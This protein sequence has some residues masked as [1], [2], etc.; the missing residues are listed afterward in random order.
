MSGVD[1]DDD[2]F[3][4]FDGS[5][6][7][8]NDPEEAAANPGL[9]G[10]FRAKADTPFETNGIIIGPDTIGNSVL[11][12]DSLGGGAG[13]LADGHTVAPE[14]KENAARN[15]MAR[16][17]AN[18]DDSEKDDS[19]DDG[20]EAEDSQDGDED[21][22]EEDDDDDDDENDSDEEE[23]KVD[24]S[25]EARLVPP[26]PI[27]QAPG[28]DNG[29]DKDDESFQNSQSSRADEEIGSEFGSGIG[30]SRDIPTATVEQ[31]DESTSRAADED[32]DD[33]PP[34]VVSDSIPFRVVSDVAEDVEVDFLDKG[35]E[36]EK[37]H[38]RTK[39]GRHELVGE[40]Y[41]EDEV[42][43]DVRMAEADDGPIDADLVMPGDGSRVE[44]IIQP[45]PVDRH[46]EYEICAP[47][48]YVYRV[49]SRT[50]GRS[51]YEIEYDDGARF[52]IYEKDL[53]DLPNG[54]KALHKFKRRELEE[55]D[56]LSSAEGGLKRRRMRLTGENMSSFNDMSLDENRSFNPSSAR[57]F[58]LEDEDLMDLDLKAQRRRLRT[59]AETGRSGIRYS[60][61]LAPTN[62]N[63]DGDEARDGRRLRARP[64]TEQSRDVLS[65]RSTRDDDVDELGGEDDA[66]FIPSI[67]SDILPQKL[68]RGNWKRR[69]K[70]ST[71]TAKRC[72][73]RD[74]SIEFETARRSSRANKNTRSMVEPTNYN[75]E[76]FYIEDDQPTQPRIINVK[77]VFQ[78]LEGPSPFR[79]A[80]MQIC[81]SCSGPAR[82]P[83]KG[84]MI[85][86]Q[87]C[88]L[89]FHK[90]CIGLRKTREH[91]VTKVADD[92]FVLQCR[93]CVNHAKI[94]DPS[95]P[96]L[97]KCSVCSKVGLSCAPFSEKKPAK[98]EERLRE[99]N[100]G[101]DP[102]TPV[103]PNLVDNAD[104]VLFR[105]T[106]CHRGFHYQHLPPP[107][108]DWIDEA[109][110]NIRKERLAEYSIDGKC[111]DC[112]DMTAK[113]EALIAWR[114]VGKNDAII[115][116][117]DVVEDDKEYLIKWEDKSY[118][119]CEWRPGSWV[120]GA[121]NTRIRQTLIK[122][123]GPAGVPPVFEAKDAFPEEYLYADIIFMVRY[124]RNVK[125]RSKKEGLACIGDI[126]QIM[127]KFQGLGY[128][129]VV[130]DEPPQPDSGKRWTTFVSA[131]DEYLNGKHFKSDSL[132]AMR[133]RVK[134]FQA[135]KKFEVISK[136]P[137]VLRRGKL[138]P[139]QM[140]GLNWLLLNY[141]KG[142]S[143]VLA[144]EM[145]LGKTVQVIA[146][147]STLVLET[148]RTW[149][150]LVVVPNS[151]CANWRREIKNWAPDLRVVSYHGGRVPQSMA[152][153]YELFP[154]GTQTMHAHVVIMSY[155]SAQDDNTRR[156]F[157]NVR[158]SGLVVD[159]GQRLKNDQNLL[160]LAL[161]AMR[162]SFRL[163]LTGTPL[164][165]NKRELF[166]LLQFIDS[167]NNA[168]ELDKTYSTITAENLPEL[169]KLIRP[170]FLRRTKAEVLKFLPPM[171]QIIVPVSMTVVQEKLC[172][173][174][175]AKNP[176][177]IRSIFSKDQVKGA[178]RGS[179]N[180][181]LMQLRKCLCHPFVYSE[182][183]EDKSVEVEQMHRNLIEASAKLLLLKLMLP[184]LKERGHRVLIFSQFLNQLDII[185]DFLHIM[186]M[187][188]QR[189]DGSLSS[190]EKQKRIDAYNTP[191]SDLFAFLLSTRAGGVGINLA[192]AD[193]V[194]VLDPDFNP[195]QDIQAFSRAHRIGQKKKV[196]CFQFMTK[197]SVE[198][199]I[200]QIGRSKMA[201]DHALI[202]TMD[203]EDD[204]GNDLESILRHGAQA[205][206]SE[207]AAQNRIV[208]DDASVDKLLDRSQV[209]NTRTDDERTAES[210]FSFARVWANETGTLA[211][212]IELTTSASVG[213]GGAAV[214]ND[215]ALS[216][217][218]NII[219][220]REAEAARLAEAQREV[221]GRGGRRRNKVEYKQPRYNDNDGDGFDGDGSDGVDGPPEKKSRK[222]K[223]Q[224]VDEDGEFSANDGSSTDDDDDDS[225]SHRRSRD[226]PA[227][228]L[229]AE[230]D[231]VLITGTPKKNAKSAK[232]ATTKRRAMPSIPKKTP[233]VASP[234]KAT[235]SK[236]I[237]M[238][239]VAK[240]ASAP[241]VSPQKQK[242]AVA[243]K[244]LAKSKKRQ[245]DTGLKEIGT[246]ASAM[247]S[248]ARKSKTAQAQL[249]AAT[250][251]GPKLDPKD[252]QT[253]AN[254]V[255]KKSKAVSRLP[256]ERPVK[257]QRIADTAEMVVDPP[258][259]RTP[260]LTGGSSP[261]LSTVSST[262][263]EIVSS[264]ACEPNTNGD[265]DKTG[266][267][268][269]NTAAPQTTKAK[270]QQPQQP[271]SATVQWSQVATGPHGRK[272][273]LA[274]A[275][276]PASSSRTTATPSS[277]SSSNS[278]SMFQTI[279][280]SPPATLPANPLSRSNNSIQALLNPVTSMQ[281]PMVPTF[282]MHWLL[283]PQA[284]GSLHQGAHL[285]PAMRPAMHTAPSM[286]PNH[287]ELPKDLALELQRQQAQSLQ[288]NIHAQAMRISSN[289]GPLTAQQ[290]PAPSEACHLNTTSSYRQRPDQLPP[291]AL[292]HSLPTPGQEPLPTQM[293]PQERPRKPTKNA[294]FGEGSEKQLAWAAVADIVTDSSWARNASDRRLYHLI[295]KHRNQ[296]Q[297]VA[298]LHDVVQQQQRVLLIKKQSPSYHQQ[299][300]LRQHG[301]Q[302]GEPQLKDF[303]TTEERFVHYA[304]ADSLGHALITLKNYAQKLIDHYA[305]LRKGDRMPN[306]PEWAKVELKRTEDSLEQL[307]NVTSGVFSNPP[308]LDVNISVPLEESPV[309]APQPISTSLQASIPNSMLV[310]TPAPL[311]V[312]GTPSTGGPAGT[313]GPIGQPRDKPMPKRGRPRKSI[314]APQPPAPSPP[315]ALTSEK[316]PP[317][318]PAM[319]QHMLV[320]LSMAPMS[321]C[322]RCS[323]LH[324]SS[325]GCANLECEA[326]IR[327]AL[328]AL[329]S[330]EADPKEKQAMRKR[331]VTKLGEIT[332]R[333][334][335]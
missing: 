331:L 100:D 260:S 115:A 330:S 329:R 28:S 197:D 252:T 34:P 151:T 286:F 307:D 309:P 162:I 18:N 235:P 97:D 213:A 59:L 206:F 53:Y 121:C 198:E 301:V 219:R 327:L 73:S 149:P 136:Q 98:E 15:D 304:T 80:H 124:K 193:T 230:D 140:E 27:I 297:R 318:V 290:M 209:E 52:N 147:V 144:D 47:S 123:N 253:S 199:K 44:V 61:R 311:P 314:P 212:D 39:N 195:H 125:S 146:L 202:E 83:N 258:V 246:A 289:N 270:S 134:D 79:D 265:N 26:P 226:Q 155:D 173:S 300:H 20:T 8:G 250:T 234:R 298:S 283:P 218:D 255:A 328:D 36:D 152:Y 16:E 31:A 231:A 248:S 137:A 1:D 113:I 288:Q 107:S 316:T 171:A 233:T 156:L 241:Q 103:D 239:S 54:T 275:P 174:I 315:P 302:Q 310:P 295:I 335:I 33:G 222:K 120:F 256:G 245:A 243:K 284:A 119:H 48:N 263:V 294:C 169:H 232:N 177:L 185:E 220:E 216:V 249:V 178:E 118:D 102:I 285:Y 49:V 3:A 24:A 320:Q 269:T 154:E 85:Y 19:W 271:G 238:K 313:R 143:V 57:G 63:N 56:E 60:S 254:S 66:D 278:N 148:P 109:G 76:S 317:Q 181:I 92:S 116:F 139:Y 157:H 167:S 277:T 244:T 94:K 266:N 274:K 14:A 276:A 132:L 111:H 70:G 326:G 282:Q 122:K 187:T 208:Y 45:L 10:S 40:E 158:W 325:G 291:M 12:F 251:K 189:L 164:Q 166:N 272:V 2:L 11:D 84:I 229:T 299:A 186:G 257:K 196:L 69:G 101:V 292:T 211:D 182:A 114:P 13:A 104:N 72:F 240:K 204:A 210:Q 281:S 280:G 287:K 71:N 203:A 205:L 142:K 237:P 38:I 117:D 127:V 77:E 50:R 303:D 21:T 105:C 306:L 81:N 223:N 172:K 170:Y 128:D 35:I 65:H 91:T 159:E 88:S 131:Y 96:S 242:T 67:Q 51:R 58:G 176:Q 207:E 112:L 333:K 247:T 89:A 296:R 25:L 261:A 224:R 30:H 259:D 75:D 323:A 62:N 78:P 215:A 17:D 183:I 110:A 200:M 138:M 268:D 29:N 99:E 153:K 90:Q 82:T 184:K 129:A 86:C 46:D 95:V 175:M 5:G 64:S 262:T 324:P 192:T 9:D 87:G 236:A 188:Y 42:G 93:F 225:S 227:G 32:D 214:A 322:R 108:A 37:A 141:Y 165:N 279:N 68:G 160:Y 293:G 321:R 6:G 332:T 228:V 106:Q 273:W 264:L 194:I 201:L 150:F 221:L 133:Q 22:D 43:E 319:A 74:G 130:W 191:D 267:T 145:G 41:E 190:L 179:L 7:N 217:W 23:E 312:A 4:L 305:T 126:E 135:S 163:L 180:N 168:M 161:R 308:P 55:A 334:K